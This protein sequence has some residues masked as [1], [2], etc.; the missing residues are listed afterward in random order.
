MAMET[1]KFKAPPPMT[2]PTENQNKN[3][4]CEFHR[5][6][7]HSTYDCIH[8]RR[9]IEEAVKSGQLSHLINEKKQGVSEENTQKTTHSFFTGR[10]ISFPPLASSDGQENPIVIEAEVEG[11]LIHRISP[12]PYNGI[13]GRPGRRKVQA[14][15]SAAYGMLKFL[16]EEGIVT[17]CSN[18]I[19]PTECRMVVEAPNG[20]LPKEPTVMEG[21]KVAIHPEYPEQTITIGGSLLEKG[22]MEL[23]NLLKDHLDIFAWKPADMTGVPRSIAE[24]RLNIREGC[25]LI[26][27][28]RRG[29]APDRNK[30][31]QE[32]V[33]KLVEARIMRDVHYHDWLLNSIMSNWN[34]ESFCRYH[35]KC[36]L[37]AYKGYH[38]I[39]MAEKDEEKTAF[40]TSQGVFLLYKDAVRSQERWSNILA[41]G[42]KSV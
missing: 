7:G 16:V 30:A 27:Q 34:V 18:I 23:C 17:L 33:T 38:Q 11:H 32:E 9:Q 40:H 6:K 37:D 5:K 25:Q 22:R 29:E 10:E 35:F 19:I 13:I 39:H 2:K 28:K 41:A 42:G 14:V 12:S 15:P 8:L 1:V 24:H 21:V 4:F 26:R 3:K 20:S 36:F 31:I